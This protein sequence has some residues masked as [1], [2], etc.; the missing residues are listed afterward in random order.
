[1]SCMLGPRMTLLLVLKPE[2]GKFSLALSFGCG[3]PLDKEM[4]VCNKKNWLFE[5]VGIARLDWICC[6]SIWSPFE[7]QTVL[8]ENLPWFALMTIACCLCRFS[9]TSSWLRRLHLPPSSMRLEFLALVLLAI[10][11]AVVYFLST[12]I[13]WSRYLQRLHYWWFST[14]AF[15]HFYL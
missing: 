4:G 1:M 3:F 15:I 10:L 11:L 9:L 2:L 12:S 5:R 14:Y 8:L 13:L 6:L 7:L